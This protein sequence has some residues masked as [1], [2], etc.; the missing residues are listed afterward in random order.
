MAT[1]IFKGKKLSI[2][3]QTTIADVHKWISSFENA[4][5]VFTLNLQQVQD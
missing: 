3:H 2:S 4:E 5:K 1:L